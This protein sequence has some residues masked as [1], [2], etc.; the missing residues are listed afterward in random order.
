[1]R[2]QRDGL[3]TTLVTLDAKVRSPSQ[4]RI[5]DWATANGSIANGS[6]SFGPPDESAKS[7]LIGRAEKHFSQNQVECGLAKNLLEA[8]RDLFLLRQV[9]SAGSHYLTFWDTGVSSEYPG[10]TPAFRPMTNTVLFLFLT[11]RVCH[12]Y[13]A[14]SSRLTSGICFSARPLINDYKKTDA[15]E[16]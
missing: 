7:H 3:A 16:S 12:G 5:P 1:M 2:S 14:F 6:H 15:A 9:L 13:L 10:R 4:L 8:I 11:A